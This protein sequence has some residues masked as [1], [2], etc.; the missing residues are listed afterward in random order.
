MSDIVERLRT[1]EWDAGT[2]SWMPRAKVSPLQLEAA[3]EIERLRDAL[4]QISHAPNGKV[5]CADGHEEC[6]LI[7]RAA[8]EGKE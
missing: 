7:A 2:E 3:N 4:R 8:L 5:H 1:V 6:V